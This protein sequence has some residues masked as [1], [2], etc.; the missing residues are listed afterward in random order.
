MLKHRHREWLVGP[1][2]AAFA[3]LGNDA[4]A[5]QT[6]FGENGLVTISIPDFADVNG[7]DIVIDNLGRIVVSGAVGDFF[8]LFNTQEI[9]V[10]RLLPDGSLDTAFDDDG[11]AV[12][13]F[14]GSSIHHMGGLALDD[15][16]RIVVSAWA[17]NVNPGL[18][19]FGLARFTAD[20]TAD[21]TFDLD[22]HLTTAFPDA[23]AAANDVAIMADGDIVA[24]GS[25]DPDDGPQMGGIAR[26]NSSGALEVAFGNGGLVTTVFPTHEL[27]TGWE[28]VA[29]DADQRI[30]T[31]GAVMD[32]RNAAVARYL[33]DGGLDP[34]FGDGGRVL[35]DFGQL[36]EFNAVAHDQEGRVVLAGCVL[37]PG[38]EA[39]GFALAR[40]DE[41]G[42]LDPSFGNGGIVTT[43]LPPE[44]Q[45]SSPAAA[46]RMWR[47][48]QRAAS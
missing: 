22:G 31:A 5:G 20:G 32:P 25:A 21:V 19:E 26:Y 44:C 4:G 2:I 24:V 15:L 47:S 3:L 18:G 6:G 1:L 42:A 16:N 11:S 39:R 35:V 48:T 14:G 7:V 33:A 10:A 43:P 34:A 13:A 45:K 27:L 23:F 30:V 29:V 28:A 38:F 12:T 17:V 8:A 40:L 46:L 41:S 36:S 37:V 9:A